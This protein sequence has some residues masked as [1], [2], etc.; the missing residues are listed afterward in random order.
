M[1]GRTV[2]PLVNSAKGRFVLAIAFHDRCDMVVATAV[3]SGGDLA[4]HEN[5]VVKFLNSEDVRRSAAMTLGL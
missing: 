4:V 5:A 2:L 1:D 3:M